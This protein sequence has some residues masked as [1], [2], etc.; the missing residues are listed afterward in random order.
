MNRNLDSEQ[1]DAL[2]DAVLADQSWEE[3]N[4]AC[5]AAALGTF[6]ARQRT[7]RTI[8]W[9]ACAAVLLAVIGGA[10]YWHGHYSVTPAPQIAAQP[11]QS[12]ERAE[13][14]RY[15]T[16]AE[17]IAAFPEGSCFLAEIDGQKQLVFLNE[18]VERQY[19]S[20]VVDQDSVAR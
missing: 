11:P 2:L 18:S 6:R 1:N 15:L 19:V 5:K 13:T 3:T 17:L 16:D 8:R 9:A 10:L 12:P 14:R 7:R 20:R 4:N